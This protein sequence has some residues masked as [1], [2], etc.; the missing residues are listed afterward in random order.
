MIKV[1][2]S[3]FFLLLLFS[4]IVITFF[5]FI[6]V[7]SFSVDDYFLFFYKTET[8]Q[9]VESSIESGRWFGTFLVNLIGNFSGVS[10]FSAIILAFVFLLIQWILVSCLLVEQFELDYKKWQTPLI[11]SLCF[12]H[13]STTELLTFKVAVVN[14]GFS[15]V[16]LFAIGGW[17]L[18]KKFNYKFLIGSILIMFALATY[19][20]FINILLVLT[21][22]GILIKLLN[23]VESKAK[24]N[25]KYFINNEYFVKMAAIV[26]AL[27]FYFI[28]NKI[29]LAALNLNIT[30]RA[31]FINYNE[32]PER[33][34]FLIKYYI[35]V[36]S[37]KDYFLIPPMTKVVILISLL[38]VVLTI[39]VAILK[40]KLVKLHVKIITIFITIA[41][42]I[43]ALFSSA[44]ASSF[45]KELWLM[46]RTFSGFGFFLMA[47]FILLFKFSTNRQVLF[48]FT[49]LLCIL[50]FSFISIDHNVANEQ[51][52]LNQL[53]R[54]KA[55]RIVNE[56][57]KIKNYNEKR[58]YINQSSNCRS[59][60]I[61]NIKT[62]IGDM[63][64]SAFCASWSKYELLQY[65]SGEK[66]NRTTQAEN[67]HLDSLYQA[68][69]DTSKPRWPANGVIQV[70]DEIIA[71][72]P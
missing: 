24:F 17:F 37:E 20:S 72:Y 62:I 4:I 61:G 18:I 15:F 55:I 49:S 35:R 8:G 3:K 58:I 42:L 63:N 43:F 2:P 6:N 16:Y 41:L 67:L 36:F 48:I 53:D 30:S 12:I 66:F 23:D 1:I 10:G 45:L 11:I 25:L 31:T 38:S 50:I 44:L 52:Y 9:L 68:L 7:N 51:N 47:I 65:V 5:P 21:I 70:S 46:P 22:V 60:Q 28:V 39:G 59:N 14:L 13:I 29:L 33:L 54:N 34:N 56:V 64:I 19:Q 32:V 40:F 69:P 26:F 57:E 71:V 27:V